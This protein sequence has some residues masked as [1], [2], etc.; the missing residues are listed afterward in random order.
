MKYIEYGNM[1]ASAIAAGTMRISNLNETETESY[2]KEALASGINFFDHADIYGGG[3]CEE[4]FGNYLKKHPGDRDKMY[5][6][7]KCGIREGYF[8][9]SREHIIEAVEGILKRLN[10]DH[11]DCLL[12]H[13]PDVLMEPEEVD[14]AFER[15]SSEGKVLNFGVSNMN[16]YQLEFLQ[17]RLEKPLVADQ[18]QMSIVHTPLIDSGLNVNMNN[19]ASIMR[20]AG[21]LEYLRE[22]DMV[23]QIWSPLQI[24]YFEGSFLGSDKYRKLNEVMD[25]LADKYVCGKDA[26]ACAWLL[27]LPMKVQV[28]LGTANIEHL[29][30][31]ARAADIRLEREEW[32]RLYT[33]AG[34]VLP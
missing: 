14:E 4:L 31:G 7:S 20:D 10:T 33:A 2:I 26:I 13:R 12:L 1:K 11:L 27:R 29:Q 30:S 34:N 28:M 18:L 9:F 8:D 19:D 22:K 6:Q 23:L 25:E 17:S 5:I 21:T 16:R 32:Y 15:L 24:G 3:R